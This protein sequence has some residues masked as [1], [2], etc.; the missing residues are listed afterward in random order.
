MSYEGM[1]TPPVMGNNDVPIKV[2]GKGICE[3]TVEGIRIEG[4]EQ[5]NILNS[6]MLV[7]LFFL[8]FGLLVFFGTSVWPDMPDYIMLLPFTIAIVPFLR[9]SGDDKKGEAVSLLVPWS[10]VKKV[11]W[12]EQSGCIIVRI[13]K[14]KESN[15]S[16][17]GA[18]YFRPD[19][20]R[21][22]L[23]EELQSHL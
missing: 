11:F 7:G 10:R 12:D 16:Y 3:P 22:A 13:K 19:D 15:K 21:Q 18:F 20:A 6:T 1:Y 2:T 17:K 23:I 5:K 14:H 9:S 4:F 8:L